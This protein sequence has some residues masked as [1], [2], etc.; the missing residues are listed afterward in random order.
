M[1]PGI[2]SALENKLIIKTTKLP[3]LK[4]LGNA[5]KKVDEVWI[6]RGCPYCKASFEKPTFL[7]FEEVKNLDNRQCKFQVAANVESHEVSMSQRG[8]WYY[9]CAVAQS[10]IVE[11]GF[12]IPGFSVCQTEKCPMYQTWQLLRARSG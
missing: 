8:D 12:S 11:H 4:E 6:L 3:W 2:R 1:A 7:T 10:T 5:G 9:Q